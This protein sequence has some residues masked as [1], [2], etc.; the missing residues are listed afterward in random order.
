MNI[1]RYYKALCGAI[2]LGIA[3]YILCRKKLPPAVFVAVYWVA[4]TFYW[5]IN[6]IGG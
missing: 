6:F 3:I 2:A 1:L 4:V 5:G